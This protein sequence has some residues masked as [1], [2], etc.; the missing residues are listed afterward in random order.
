[1]LMFMIRVDYRNSIIFFK[2][3]DTA[4]SQSLCNTNI[5]VFIGVDL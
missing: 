2:R 5:D 3:V 1:M 4:F